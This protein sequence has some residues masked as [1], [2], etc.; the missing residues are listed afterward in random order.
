MTGAHWANTPPPWGGG[1]KLGVRQSGSGDEPIQKCSAEG[2]GGKPAGVMPP[3]TSS[4]CRGVHLRCGCCCCTHE[5]RPPHKPPSVLGFV[6]GGGSSKWA[7]AIPCPRN[8]VSSTHFGGISCRFRTW[9]VLRWAVG[10]A[11]ES[12]LLLLRQVRLCLLFWCRPPPPSSSRPPTSAVSP[13]P[14]PLPDCSHS[15][16]V[17]GQPTPL[18]CEGRA[19]TSPVVVHQS[20][21]NTAG[22]GQPHPFC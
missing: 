20:V 12:M 1:R 4:A 6:R 14:L 18:T 8:E 11:F 7:Q 13:S 17:C 5:P 22:W 21:R 2:L 15:K 9:N 16:L 3:S 10:P 19:R